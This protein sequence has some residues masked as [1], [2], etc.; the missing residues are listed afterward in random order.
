MKY[1]WYSNSTC[2]TG[3]KIGQILGVNYGTRPPPIGADLTICW[4]ARYPKVRLKHSTKRRIETM[5][6]IN[7][8]FKIEQN[9]DKYK[10]LNIMRHSG[11]RV[12]NTIPKHLLSEA[13]ENG[14]FQYPIIGRKFYHQQGNGF[15]LCNTHEEALR[16]MNLVD[17]F[18][19]YIPNEDEYRIQVFGD[20]IL[21]VSKKVQVQM[22]ADKY[23]RSNNKGWHY[24]HKVWRDNYQS[25]ADEAKKAV[26]SLGLDFG[27]VD[28]VVSNN[29]PFIIEVNSGCGLGESGLIKFADKIRSVT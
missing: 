18:V 17:Y 1:V 2:V 8:I 29:Q 19:E 16:A 12:P 28:L 7:N 26:M 22:D 11:V 6:Y 20:D 14:L 24:A 4:G 25:M 21:R 10:A 27:G 23:C 13:E 3:R 9:A 15:Y 5:R